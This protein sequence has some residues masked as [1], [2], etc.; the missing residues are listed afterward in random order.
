MRRHPNQEG[1]PVSKADEQPLVSERNFH[2]ADGLLRRFRRWV[3]ARI[4]QEVPEDIAI[5]AFDCKKGQCTD[6]EWAIC[7]RRIKRAAGELWPNVG[8]QT[9]EQPLAV[10]QNQPPLPVGG[11]K[12]S[13]LEEPDAVAR[14]RHGG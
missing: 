12:R 5:C 1:T 13:A 10:Q 9:P 6:G 11:V 7:D 3:A 14:Q 4:V 8:P 2:S